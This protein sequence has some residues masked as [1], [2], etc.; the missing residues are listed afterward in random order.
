MISRSMIDD[1]I[2]TI[3]EMKSC[4]HRSSDHRFDWY[5]NLL[6]NNLPR[7]PPGE[8]IGRTSQLD[9]QS[10]VL[11]RH[12]GRPSDDDHFIADL[13]RFSSDALIGQLSSA[14]PLDGPPLLHA[15]F[16]GSLEGH[17]GMRVAIDE[18]HQLSVELDLFVDV[19]SGTVGMVRVGGGAD[20]QCEQPKSAC[21]F[22]H[23]FFS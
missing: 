1:W 13:E 4:D 20:H 9:H 6:L 2:A 8:P 16:V 3:E 22:T 10:P 12:A 11:T 18:L 19:V 14:A 7:R 23:H 21:D 17:E 15:V 5:D